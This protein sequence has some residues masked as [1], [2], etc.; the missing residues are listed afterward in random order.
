LSEN[1]RRD[2]LDVSD[3]PHVAHGVFPETRAPLRCV[4]E[5]V[6]IGRHDRES[7]RAETDVGDAG[8]PEAPGEQSRGHEQDGRHRHLAHD[9]AVA[10][11]PPPPS[12]LE[13]CAV[14]LQIGHEPT[15][16]A[17]QCGRE[18]G[19]DAR[20]H[21]GRS[22]EGEHPPVEPQVERD[23][24]RQREI[25]DGQHADEPCGNRD[26]HERAE[27]PED[28]AL[29]EE[30]PD[31]P[32]PARTDREP[33]GDLALACRGTRQEHSG[34]VRARDEQH[35]PDGDHGTSDHPA[36]DGIGLRVHARRG[37]GTDGDTAI[38]VGLRVRRPQAAGHDVGVRACFLDGRARLQPGF[39]EQPPRA[40]TIEAR[41][42]R[43]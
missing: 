11:R 42:A 35:E 28:H 43:G 30:L 16:R 20:E 36:Q 8:R 5:H 37:R 10:H 23:R 29:C 40:P 21:G 25:Q 24:H 15:A 19:N 33:D 9:E 41:G 3:R 32:R 17:A 31:Q 12:C 39:R 34:D 18:A 38:L 14:A 13:P 22:G 7:V 26:A 4:A 6:G 27:R 1:G 2:L